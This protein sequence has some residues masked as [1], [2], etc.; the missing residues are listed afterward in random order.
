[1]KQG[2]DGE[3]PYD[4]DYENYLVDKARRGTEAEKAEALATLWQIHRRLWISDLASRLAAQFMTPGESHELEQEAYVPFRDAVLKG[5]DPAKA[6]GPEPGLRR[7]ARTKVGHH[8]HNVIL[9]IHRWK[10]SETA[11]RYWHKILDLYRKLEQASGA[12]PDPGEIA[13]VLGIGVPFVE[14][15]LDP[16]VVLLDDV[17]RTEGAD[18]DDDT[19]TR[20]RSAAAMLAQEQGQEDESRDSRYAGDAEYE[21]R[22]DLW[23]AIHRCLRNPVASNK[24]IVMLALRGTPPPGTRAE[25]PWTIIAAELR[26]TEAPIGRPGKDGRVLWHDVHLEWALD[27]VACFCP[28]H[29]I[30]QEWPDVSR[31]FSRGVPPV[32]PTRLSDWHTQLRERF[33]NCYP[34]RLFL[35]HPN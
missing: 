31:F 22:K 28:P 25:R 1:M 24:W 33:K 2:N 3:R 35:T 15:V 29:P 12:T 11:R 14:E 26:S 9:D 18:Q 32:T 20:A 30:P 27:H 21:H 23:E 6:P 5:Y 13:R 10:R 19:S 7:Y 16:H 34:D 17:M 4:R 8:L